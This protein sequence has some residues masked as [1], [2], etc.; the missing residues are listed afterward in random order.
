MSSKYPSHGNFFNKTTQMFL[1]FFFFFLFLV[2]SLQS[3]TE[4]AAQKLLKFLLNILHNIRQSQGIHFCAFISTFCRH[5]FSRIVDLTF[6]YCSFSVD[7]SYLFFF[8]MLCFSPSHLQVNKV[9]W[10]TGVEGDQKALFSIATTPRC[11]G[12]RC[13]IPLIAPVYP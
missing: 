10:P 13:S 4:T 12:G 2:F 5:L 11:R 9:S 1:F 8:F 6:V 3:P 7:C